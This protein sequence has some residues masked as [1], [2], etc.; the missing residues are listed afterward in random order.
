MHRNTLPLLVTI[1]IVTL[2]LS[3]F[4]RGFGDA[5]PTT[6]LAGARP[7]I[8]AIHYPS[9]QA[10]INALPAGGGVVR[11]PSGKFELN[12]PLVLE[13]ED[14]QL[15]GQGTGTHI[16][17]SNTSGQPGRIIVRPKHLGRS[18]PRQAVAHRTV[19][20]STDRQ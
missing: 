10:A 4:N 3:S 7:T 17:N 19:E 8:D 14:V 20:L 9:I 1:A 2:A 15:E 12:E 5:P 13:T 16:H 11:L 6:T 18:T